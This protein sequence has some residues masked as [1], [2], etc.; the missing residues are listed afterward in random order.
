MEPIL[1]VNELETTYEVYFD[2]DDFHYTFQDERGMSF[3]DSDKDK[4]DYMDKFLNKELFAFIVVELKLCECCSLWSEVG[5]L[6]GI[7]AATPQEALK[8]F[9]EGM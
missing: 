6:S 9:K 8:V 2:S 1:R 7:H 4:Q 3:F 5:H